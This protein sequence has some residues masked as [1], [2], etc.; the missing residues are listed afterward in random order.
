MSTPPVLKSEA[1]RSARLQTMKR[2]ASAMLAAVTVVFLGVTI[3]GGGATWASYVQ[4]TAEAAMVGGLADWFAVT[5]LFRHPLGIPIPHTAIVVERKDQFAATLGEFIQE[6]FLT[7]EAILERVRGADVVT[8]LADWLIEPANA[9][10]LAG[11]LCDA[12]VAAADLVNDDEVHEAIEKAVR[13]RL[14]AYPVAPLAGRGLEHLMKEGRHQQ[15]LDV[16]LRE[17]DR[18]L[19]EHREDLRTRLAKQSPWWLPN[20]AEDRIFERLI[21]GARALVAEMLNDT[22]HHL[23]DRFE[24]RIAKL[25]VDL[26][27]SP[28]ML[29]RGE[30]LKHEMLD[31]PHVR[32]LVA[33]LWSDAKG[34]LRTQASD[35]SSELRQKVTAAIVGAGQRLHDDPLL[36]RKVEDG[37]ETA[38]SYVATRFRSEIVGLVTGTIDRWDTEETAR[39]LELLLGPDLQYIRINGTVVGALAGLALHTIAQL[40]GH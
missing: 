2:R 39:R 20:A 25:A 6:A 24:E 19:D 1:V 10:R 30:K 22:G 23:R 32:E 3:F 26:R 31:Q 38:V 40:V 4:A 14:D 28:E 35:P 8:R 27:E 34:Q 5:A 7:P 21:E 17:L 9:A 15:V 18:Y 16:G 11:E 13:E 29:E 37:V 12:A 36:R 33:S